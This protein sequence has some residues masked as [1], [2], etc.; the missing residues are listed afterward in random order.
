MMKHTRTRRDADAQRRLLTA[1]EFGA[2]FG[3][4]NKTVRVWAEQ[5]G[6]PHTRT[7]GGRMGPGHLRLDPVACVKWLRENHRQIPDELLRLA[8]EAPVH[9][10]PNMPEAA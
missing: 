6:L 9:Q 7:M 5:Q 4:V 3:V 1:T 10:A 8:G 2:L